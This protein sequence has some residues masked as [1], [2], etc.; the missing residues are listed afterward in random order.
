M[1]PTHTRKPTRLRLAAFAALG[2]CALPAPAQDRPVEMRYAHWLPP[3]HALT[4]TGWQPWAKSI[5]EASKG[6]IKIVYYPAQQLGKADDHY[7]MTRDGIADAGFVNPGYQAGR[8]PM[9]A[10]G[11]LP[12]LNGKPGPASAAFDAWYRSYA[13]TEM[14][15]VHFCF[16]HLHVGTLHSRTAISEPTQLKGLKVRSANGT[17][18]A[19]M[20]ALGATN[21]RVSA[22]EARD[23]LEKGVADAI[24]F[25]WHSILD[26]AI[27]KVARFHADMRLYS[28][29]F[30]W[31]INKDWYARLSPMQKKVIDDHCN[32]AWAA[33]VGADWGDYED[34]GEAVLA[35]AAGHTI[36]AVSPQ[37]MNQ[38]RQAVQPVY[39]QWFS[40]A[41]K[42]GHDGPQALEALRKE[43]KARGGD[44]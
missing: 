36:V 23:A 10:A 44:N 16:A 14:K 3:S 28:S 26:F 27:D 33:R 15:D 9:F 40:A 1:K 17:V 32:N 34:S 38:W 29:N 19:M 13:V 4:R 22:P 11:E 12:F 2:A 42:S 5:E 20:V 18:A 41:K 39:D 37:Q 31:V 21:V 6:S 24:T 43:L 8:F 30:A 35:K 7:D 25:P